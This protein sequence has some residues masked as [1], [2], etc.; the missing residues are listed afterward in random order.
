MSCEKHRFT[1]E[2]K[3]QVALEALSGS[4]SVGELASKYGIYPRLVSQWK[5]QAE[6]SIADSFSGTAQEV[7][8]NMRAQYRMRHNLCALLTMEERDFLQRPFSNM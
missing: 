7:H 2:F 1:A 6:A 3:T 5:Q 8:Q 4:L